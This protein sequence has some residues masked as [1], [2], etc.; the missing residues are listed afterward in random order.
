[1]AQS[2]RENRLKLPYNFFDSI[3]DERECM[4]YRVALNP[5]VSSAEL[6][7]KLEDRM[8]IHLWG[9][10][11]GK[12][13][14]Y[15]AVFA[16][17]AISNPA[18]REAIIKIDTRTVTET[19]TLEAPDSTHDA[20]DSMLIG[21]VYGTKNPERIVVRLLEYFVWLEALDNCDVFGGNP[22]KVS[23]DISLVVINFVKNRELKVETLV[24]SKREL[25]QL[26]DKHVKSGTGIVG[27]ISDDKTPLLVGQV[28]DPSND[29]V[30]WRFRVRLK[31]KG[32]GL[33]CDEA[34]NRYL[35]SVEVLISPAKFQSWLI[36][37]MHTRSRILSLRDEFY[38]AY[39]LNQISI[40]RGEINGR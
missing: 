20:D 10:V 2:L 11:G 33:T 17:N 3:V 4:H 24:V 40:S 5:W 22:R 29:D 31:R 19:N 14:N 6:Y 30:V 1:M 21:I 28:N 9:C 36:E 39:I 35:D 25:T 12:S 32:V 18:I 34:V 7:R 26:I 23:L 16:Y 8:H 27:E 15:C 13:G 38:H 37:W